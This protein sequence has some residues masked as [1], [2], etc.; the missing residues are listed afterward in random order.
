MRAMK[1]L[2]VAAA[3]LSLGAAEV[4][5]EPLKIGIIESLSGAQ[6]STGRLFATAAQYVID[7]IN[8]D[9]GFNGAPIEMRS[10]QTE[11]RDRYMHTPA[12]RAEGGLPRAYPQR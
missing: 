5:A 10:R 7:Q 3:A 11:L 1:M 9:G 4:K 6:T 8:A 2:A 12:P